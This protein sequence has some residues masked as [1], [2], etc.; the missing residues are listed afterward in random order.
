MNYVTGQEAVKKIKSGDRVFVQ[1]GAATPHH[2]LQKMVERAD[3]LRDVELVSASLHGEANFTEKQYQDSFF[4]NSL[5][6]SKSVRGAVNS[7]QGD[8][9][10]MFLSE[11]PLLFRRGVMPIDVA[12]VQVS[13]PDKHGFCSLGTAIDISNTAMQCARYVIA[14][15][16]PRLPRTH[17]DGIIHVSKIDALVHHQQELPEIERGLISEVATLIGQNCA[18][19]VEDGATL[20]T[21]IGQIPDATLASLA[22]HKELGLHTEMFSDGVIDLVEKGVITNQ[23]KKSYRGKIV[24][25]FVIGSRKLYDFVDDNPTVEFKNI[26]YVNDTAIIRTNP[27]VTAINSAIEIDLTGQVCADSIGTYQY[28]GVGGQMDFIRGA[29]L[30]EGGKPIIALPSVTSKGISRITP[31]LN[32]G[33]SVVTTRAHAHYIVTE[34]GIAFLWGKNLRQRAEALIQIAHPD[35]REALEWAAF[36]RFNKNSR[37]L[38]GV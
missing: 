25:G 5:F 18:T 19:L 2:L 3:E 32:Q 27:K 34:Y 1:G 35:H 11:I 17:G 30:S 8:Y 37:S 28:S 29:A 13:S 6:V 36:E 9:V 10:P 4:M 38:Q 20:Q 22:N 14:Q 16:N 7:G 15:V 12:L 23:H 24:T 31:F 21:G 26:D 33:A